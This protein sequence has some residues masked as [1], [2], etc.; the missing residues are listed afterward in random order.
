MVITVYNIKSVQIIFILRD[1][2]D[3]LVFYLIIKAFWNVFFFFFLYFY[4]KSTWYYFIIY[5]SKIVLPVA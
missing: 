5:N 2:K 4:Y 1:I 3:R